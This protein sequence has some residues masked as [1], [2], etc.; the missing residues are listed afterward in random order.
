MGDIRPISLVGSLYKIISKVLSV[1][2]KEV[3]GVLVS[4]TQS[5]FIHGRQILDNI[6]IA[7]ECV[8]SLQ[9]DKKEGVVCKLD[10]YSDVLINN[11]TQLLGV[12]YTNPIPP[13]HSI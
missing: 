11:F 5:A 4:S 12:G 1:R 6:L 2:I 10:R 13:F 7:N 8:D 9:R 3:M